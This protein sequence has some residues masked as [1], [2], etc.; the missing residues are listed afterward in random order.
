M[1]DDAPTTNA[2]LVAIVQSYA[3]ALDVA[4]AENDGWRELTAQAQ[5]DYAM[6]RAVARRM[7]AEDTTEQDAL[8]LWGIAASVEHPGAALIIRCNRAQAVVAAARATVGA[9]PAYKDVA[10]LLF[11]LK[12]ALTAYDAPLKEDE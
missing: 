10:R 11:A 8:N 12:A 2:D 3:A 5:A 7:F 1:T 4:M 9:D 6:L